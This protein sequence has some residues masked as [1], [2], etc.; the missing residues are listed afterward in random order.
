M[1]EG[2]I[3]PE[4]TCLDEYIEESNKQIWKTGLTPQSVGRTFTLGFGGATAGGYL[5]QLVGT[6]GW[7]CPGIHGSWCLVGLCAGTSVLATLEAV[8]I[9]KL[10]QTTFDKS[11]CRSQGD[12]KSRA[13]I[14]QNFLSNMIINI[15]LIKSS[16]KQKESPRF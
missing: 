1:K 15:P 12:L 11:Y 9:T 8:A 13:K 7:E 2:T 14:L 4:N 3:N 10:V 6:V 5:A 16:L